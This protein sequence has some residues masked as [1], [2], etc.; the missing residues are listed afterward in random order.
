MKRYDYDCFRAALKERLDGQWVRY[1][2]VQA[3]LTQLRAERL[4]LANRIAGEVTAAGKPKAIPSSKGARNPNPGANMTP[5]DTLA[6]LAKLQ[7]AA[8]PGPL[9][10][11]VY[12][13]T[14]AMAR[15]MQRPQACVCHEKGR[16]LVALCGDADDAAS[17]ADAEFFAAAR[18]AP[19]AELLAELERL[20]RENEELQKLVSRQRSEIEDL[21]DMADSVE[22]LRDIG[23]LIGCDHVNDRDGRRQLVNCVEQ[24][25]E[26]AANHE[27][28]E[29]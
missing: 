25:L 7:R 17:Q 29:Q 26:Q 1:D 9:T 6:E 11:G 27:G 8:S 28:S 2:D 22:C 3:E 20:R 23:N 19:F 15:L 16:M 5:I 4:L 12:E 14:P 10:T 18:S 21:A 24:S 13:N